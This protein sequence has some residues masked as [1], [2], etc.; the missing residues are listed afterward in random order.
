M[1]EN[2]KKNLDREIK[3]II[4]FSRHVNVLNIPG[5]ILTPGNHS[6]NMFLKLTD[7]ILKNVY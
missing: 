6:K 2:V 4:Y 1:Y 7:V 5:E 3:I